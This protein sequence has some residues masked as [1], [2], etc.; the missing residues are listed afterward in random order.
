MGTDR[1][2]DFVREPAVETEV[3]IDAVHNEAL[4]DEEPVIDRR[5]VDVLG[6]RET[7]VEPAGPLL[8]DLAAAIGRVEMVVATT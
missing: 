8:D 3:A 5:T 7:C 1:G 4:L 2:I 6:C